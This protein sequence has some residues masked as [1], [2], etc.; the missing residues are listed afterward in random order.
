[1]RSISGWL[2]ALQISSIAWPHADFGLNLHAPQKIHLL[3]R[4]HLYPGRLFHR[5]GQPGETGARAV[6]DHV[7]GIR[8]RHMK[9]TERGMKPLCQERC[10]LQPGERT[11]RE[12]YRNQDCANREFFARRFGFLFSLPYNQNRARCA[13]DDSF[14]RAPEQ[15]MLQSAI[16]LASKGRSNRHQSRG[17]N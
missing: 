8:V 6:S 17:P 15:K 1:M 7:V 16:V 13:T 2:A 9:E 4:V 11:R 3:K 14:R 5:V 12:I 10:V